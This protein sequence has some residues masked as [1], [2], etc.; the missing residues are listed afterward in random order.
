M[1]KLMPML[2]LLLCTACATAPH[3]NSQQPRL[4]SAEKNAQNDLAFY[5][6]SL[7]GTPYRYGG[8]SPQTGFDCSGFVRY[9]FRHSLGLA[10]PRTT[11]QMSRLGRPVSASQLRPGDLVFY[12]TLRRAYSHVGIYLGDNR[13]VHAP[14][15][16]KSVE[17]VRMDTDYWQERYNG[18]RRISLQ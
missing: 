4:S 15:S 12:H 13:F 10:L 18:A 7:A 5:A 2:A 3:G 8:E 9:V 1:K 14:S 6:M 17:V 11:Q 16:G